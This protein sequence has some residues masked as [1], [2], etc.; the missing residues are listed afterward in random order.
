MLS[1]CCRLTLGVGLHTLFTETDTADVVGLQ[2]QNQ[3]SGTM[4]GNI[5]QNVTRLASWTIYSNVIS[6]YLPSFSFTDTNRVDMEE[7]IANSLA[8]S[9][10][11]PGAYSQAPVTR[12]SS[13]NQKFTIGS[14]QCSLSDDGCVQSPNWPSAFAA[15]QACAI[16]VLNDGY[17]TA[18]HMNA[19]NR[20]A[21]RGCWVAEPY[22]QSAE[23][24]CGPIFRIF[25][26]IKQSNC[27]MLLLRLHGVAALLFA[28][29]LLSP[30]L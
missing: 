20:C 14:G 13:Q 22:V 24:W 17:I 26:P 3:L 30:L 2:H 8:L 15:S 21:G 6:G 7:F 29:L 18:T 27:A 1:L 28:A 19:G 25:R 4:Q 23:G 12:R 16:S 5:L 11:L 10:S 9:G